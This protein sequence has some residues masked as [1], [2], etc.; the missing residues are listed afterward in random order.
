M[1]PDLELLDAIWGWDGHVGCYQGYLPAE[2]PTFGREAYEKLL[3]WRE[4]CELV[5]A[6][7]NTGVPDITYG[8]IVGL[9]E[10]SHDSLA[11]LEQAIHDLYARLKAINPDLVFTIT[12]YAIRPLP[13]TPQSE[14]LRRDGLLHFEDPAII[15]GFWTACADTYHLSYEEVS[16]WQIRLAAI[17]DGELMRWQS[18]TGASSAAAQVAT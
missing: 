6:I 3:P 1:S 12:P 8:V 5:E 16:E 4:H 18:I 10:D 13:G 2:R 9:P 11:E 15:G 14:R 7:A 17:G